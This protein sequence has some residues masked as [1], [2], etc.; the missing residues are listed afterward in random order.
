MDK[1]IPKISDFVYDAQ[2]LDEVLMY[3]V[4]LLDDGEI[5]KAKKILREI[6]GS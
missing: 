2:K 3:V 4:C 5:E 6:T 1:Q